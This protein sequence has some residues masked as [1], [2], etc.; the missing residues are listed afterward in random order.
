MRMKTSERFVTAV[1]VAVLA[2]LMADASAQVRRAA[3]GRR[4]AVVHGE[5][6][7][8]AVGRRGGRRRRRGGRSGRRTPWCRGRR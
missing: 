8:V 2:A 3:A 6:R 1:A 4:G 7:T 5:E